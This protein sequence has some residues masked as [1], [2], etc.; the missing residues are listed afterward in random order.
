MRKR[1][2]PIPKQ[3]H[4]NMPKR[5]VLFVWLVLSLSGCSHLTVA[6]KPVDAHSIAWDENQQNAGIIDCD[7]KGCLV[8][9]NW[10][11]KYKQMESHFKNYIQA[12]AN[13]KQEGANWRISYEVLN[14]F[15]DLKR[16]ER[17]A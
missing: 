15:L 6:P 1:S 12:D 8:T 10:M 7:A 14:H 17:G 9:M 5:Y 4:N 3:P 16:A 13:M 11:M 2:S